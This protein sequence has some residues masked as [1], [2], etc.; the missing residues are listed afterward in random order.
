MS[1]EDMQSR[2]YSTMST[3]QGFQ[4]YDLTQK[5]KFQAEQVKLGYQ[6][7]NVV[8]VVDNAQGLADT[9]LEFIKVSGWVRS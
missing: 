8:K 6:T 1:Q 5:M 4:L 7:D 3:E 9:V 2:V